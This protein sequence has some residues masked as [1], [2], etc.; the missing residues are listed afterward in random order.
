MLVAGCE[1]LAEVVFAAGLVLFS[2]GFVL[3]VAGC[4]AFAEVVLAAG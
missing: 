2:E 3:F 1:A 4:E